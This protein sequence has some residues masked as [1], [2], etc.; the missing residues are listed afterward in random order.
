VSLV[1]FLLQA[2]GSRYLGLEFRSIARIRRL[3]CFSKQ[4]AKA[5]LSSG[6]IVE[7]PEGVKR[8]QFR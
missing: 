8:G 5:S 4:L 2:L 7:I 1:E 3:L 6:G